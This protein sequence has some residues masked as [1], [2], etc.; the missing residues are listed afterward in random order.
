MLG[1]V[2]AFAVRL[3]KQIPIVYWSLEIRFL[4][5]FTYGMAR[6]VKRL[7]RICH[8]RAAFLIIQ[9]SERA[10]S[11][12]SEN[13][14]SNPKTVIVPNS[15]LGWPECKRSDFFQKRFGISPSK[16]RK[17]KEPLF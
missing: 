12:I 13:R 11:L 8:R 5:D 16:Y 14:I 2:T 3:L 9:D 1:L 4:N 17:N 7:E 15:P 6:V 10:T